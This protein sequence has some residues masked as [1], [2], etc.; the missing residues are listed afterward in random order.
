MKSPVAKKI[1]Y[2]HKEHGSLREDPYAWLKNKSEKAVIEHLDEENTYCKVKMNHTEDARQKLYDE[3]LGRIQENDTSVP[4][5]KGDWWYYSRTEEKKAYRIHCRK[6]QSIDAKE[7]IILD[8]NVLAEGQKYFSINRMALNP[9]QTHIAW[10]QDLDGG[11]QF[12]LFILDLQTGVV[13][14]NR[15]TGLKWSLAWGDN[16][17]IFYVKG[18]HAER[19]YQVWR[20]IIGTKVTEDVLIMHEPDE[21]FFLSVS[22]ARNGRYVKLSATSNITSEVL[23]I[24]TDDILSSPSVV[25]PRQQGVEYSVVAGKQSLFVMSNEDAMN[26]QVLQI[27]EDETSVLIPHDPTLLIDYLDSFQDFLVIVGKQ[28]GLPVVLIYSHTTNQKNKLSF[29]DA[30]FDLNAS[31][32]PNFES[33]QYRLSY[34]SP[35]TSHSVFSYNMQ[36]LERETLKVNPVHNFIPSEYY[37]ERIWALASDGTKVPISIARRK[38]AVGSI[39]ILLYGYGSYGAAYTANFRSS[40]LSLLD[41]GMGIAIAHIRGGSEMG[42]DWY[43][44]GK[45]FQKMNTFTDF[46]TCAEHLIESGYTSKEK[47]AIT[48]G[49]AGGLLMGAVLNLRPDLCKACV[50]RV[51]FVDVVGTMMDPNLPLTVIE[52]EEWGDPNEKNVYDYMLSYSPYDNIEPKPYPH[53][54]VTAGLNDPR[55]GY[56]EPAK[57]VAKLREYKTDDNWLLLRT[58]MGAGHGGASG[59]YGHLDDLSWMFAFVL[60]RLEIEH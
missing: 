29:P 51:P 20:R 33:L 28:H 21:R 11:E 43:E 36:T 42:R 40:W 44:S 47:L 48:G 10:T 25:I 39:P 9:A 35:V 16:C 37:C 1:H 46:I 34:S 14:A 2:L 22:R 49:S 5:K 52:Y 3:M 19:P 6:F 31:S 41:R 56:W 17:T 45:F 54:L 53:L 7:E 57:W 32:N 30:T 58:N 8:E 24:D 50:A 26:F 18:D 55:V 27:I 60:D 38:D 13:D 15:V 23:L 59:R 4:Y 12:E